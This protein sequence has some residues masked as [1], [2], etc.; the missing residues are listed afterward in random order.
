[1]QRSWRNDT[2]KLT[3]ISCLP[4]SSQPLSFSTG[5]EESGIHRNA[6][7]TT[8][9]KPEE[10]DAPDRMLGDVNLFL[11]LED[12]DENIDNAGEEESSHKLSPIVGELELMIAQ[13]EKQRHGFGRASLLCFMNYIAIHEVEI[14]RGFLRS[15]ARN[16]GQGQRN[17]RNQE[18]GLDQAGD[19]KLVYLVVRIGATNER[20]LALFEGLGFRKVTDEPNYFG[21]LE[22]R[23]YG[24]DASD[25]RGLMEQFG[26]QGYNE[27]LYGGEE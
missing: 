13:K 6:A 7:T 10:D 26:V 16:Q 5:V 8:R 2:D 17:E 1:M 22:L 3:F 20:S 21:E 12:E 18:Y 11:K 14:V 19:A 25:A 24:F 23:K 9:I 27:V 15:H 4:L